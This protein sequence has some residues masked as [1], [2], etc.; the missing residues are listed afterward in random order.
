MSTHTLGAL[1]VAAL[2]ALSA[3]ARAQLPLPPVGAA[4]LTTAPPT[5]VDPPPARRLN[6]MRAAI[7]SAIVPGAGQVYAREPRRGLV[8]GAIWA[9]GLALAFNDHSDVGHVGALVSLGTVVYAVM[10]APAAVRRTEAR[11][12]ARRA[13]AV[14]N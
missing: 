14:T 1:A 8:F 5:F 12:A 3:P 9:G 4:R 2:L 13:K 7:Y 11:E 6:P 10:D